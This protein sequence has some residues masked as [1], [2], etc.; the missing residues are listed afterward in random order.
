MG[1]EKENAF[2]KEK[3]IRLHGEIEQ[4]EILG[5]SMTAFC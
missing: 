4:K 5:C 2:G 3:A 1:Q